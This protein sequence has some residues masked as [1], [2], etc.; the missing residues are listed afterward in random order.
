ADGAH[1]A[2]AVDADAAAEVLRVGPAGE[3][4]RR[5]RATTPAVALEQLAER[6]GAEAV[7]VDQ[8]RRRAAGEELAQWHEG[9]AGAED[10]LL[11]R[12]DDAHA[13]MLVADGGGDGV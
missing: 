5:R 10:R 12:V 6:P 4:Q 11:A 1:A 8:Q 3:Q 7:A 2:R 13:A 9:A